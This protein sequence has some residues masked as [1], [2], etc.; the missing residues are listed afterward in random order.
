[1]GTWNYRVIRRTVIENDEVVEYYSINEVYYSDGGN[2]VGCTVHAISLDYCNSIDELQST[3]E[4]IFDAI[5]KP[6]LDYEDF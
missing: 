3:I 4:K 2:A 1:M 6:V 5:S